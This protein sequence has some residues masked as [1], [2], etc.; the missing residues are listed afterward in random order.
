MG[1]ISLAY[2]ITSN[3]ETTFLRD[4]HPTFCYLEAYLSNFAV[5][6]STAWT[7]IICHTLYM[8]VYKNTSKIYYY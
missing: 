1:S 6:T 7:S 3:N 2:L 8:Q 5:L 4:T